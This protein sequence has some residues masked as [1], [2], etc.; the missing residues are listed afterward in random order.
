MTRKSNPTFREISRPHRAIGYRPPAPQ[1]ILPH[2][3]DQPSEFEA[4][5]RIGAQRR[6]SMVQ[7]N[8]WHLPWGQV[9]SLRHIGP[10]PKSITLGW[11]NSMGEYHGLELRF[12][13]LFDGRLHEH[14]TVY[15]SSR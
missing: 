8:R 14:G 5:G 3:A 6:P 9:S 7:T 13:L 12:K 10:P 15:Y 4:S 2:R 11:T 1:T